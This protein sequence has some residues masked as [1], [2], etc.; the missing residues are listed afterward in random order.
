MAESK[1]YQEAFS[2][3]CRME[4]PLRDRLAAFSAVVRAYGA[5]YAEAYDELVA[6]VASGRAEE[7]APEVGD[8]L[9]PFLLPDQDG[10]LVSLASLLESGPLVV[11]FNRGHWCEYCM[12]ELDQF[13]RAHDV[14]RAHGVRVVS[15]MPERLE[16][17]RKVSE[18]HGH[19]FLVLS[20]M[21]NGYALEL[22]L[23]MWLGDRVRELLQRDGLSLEQSQ[24]NDGWF[25][26]IPATFVVGQ[27]GR[28][29][30]RLVDPDFRHRMD[31]DEIIAVLQ[32]AGYGRK[33]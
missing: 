19:S 7:S 13:V 8:A 3:V 4:G 27:S 26:P 2:E 10:H 9:P 16:Y 20:D 1:T 24:S 23:V 22:G 15:I 29:L 32:S 5:P 12:L 28:I 25:V 30:A 18:R 14:L 31:I 11:S 33:N 6:K 21:D 17:L